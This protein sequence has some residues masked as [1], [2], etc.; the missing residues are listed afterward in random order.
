MRLHSRRPQA[1]FPDERSRRAFDMMIYIPADRRRRY[2]H[3]GLVP[4]VVSLIVT[5]NLAV[6]RAANSEWRL[7]VRLRRHQGTSVQ[8]PHRVGFDLRQ[9]R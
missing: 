5:V 1:S 9:R 6:Q 4:V 7:R 2:Q 8:I 3:T